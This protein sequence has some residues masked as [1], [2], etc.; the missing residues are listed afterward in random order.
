VRVLRARATPRAAVALG[1]VCAVRFG[2]KSGC[3]A[4][5]HLLPLGD[6]RFESPLLGTVQLAEGDTVPLLTGLRDARAP[7]L[8]APNRVLFRPARAAGLA[9]RYVARGE[10]AGVHR[11]P[12]CAGRSPWWRLGG[13]RGPAPVLYPA[14]IGTRA[15]GFENAGGLYEDKKWHALFPRALPAWE[16]ALLLSSTPVRLAVE[17]GARQL[18]GAQAIADVDC[19]VLAAAP[20]PRPETIAAHEPDL[21]ALW[22]AM[23]EDPVTT[24]LSAML[25][26]PAQRELDRLTGA[27]MGVRGKDVEERRRALLERVEDRLRHAAAIRAAAGRK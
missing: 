14:K 21:R 3:N 20:V 27:A 10:K 7:A 15:F 22:A 24:D 17:E 9:A 18:T 4:F 12:T 6:G 25:A 16:V 2:L 19:R 1:E 8:A 11:R 26:R 23:R 13:G 5:F